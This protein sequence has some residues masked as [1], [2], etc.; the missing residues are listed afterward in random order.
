M[1]TRIRSGSM[2]IGCPVWTRL[3]P[4]PDEEREVCFVAPVIL[5][6]SP[7]VKR[8]SSFTKLQRI[9]AWIL[10]FCNNCRMTESSRILTP[11]LTVSELIAAKT[12]GP[13]MPSL[14]TFQPNYPLFKQRN[15]SQ[16]VVVCFI[17]IPFLTLMV[18]YA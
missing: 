18:S 15:S 1:W 16:E 10:H 6:K 13:S 8:F 9:T 2:C 11:Q 3:K 7:L 17:F 14:M 5:P 4:I 12:T